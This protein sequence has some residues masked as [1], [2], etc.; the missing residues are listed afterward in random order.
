MNKAEDCFLKTLTMDE[1]HQNSFRYLVE[2]YMKQEN[3]KSCIVYLNKLI[4]MTKATSSDD[5][6]KY[7]RKLMKVY[8]AV[9]LDSS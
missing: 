6:V 8:E 9:S 7:L 3:W 1:T 4:E 5:C 2:I